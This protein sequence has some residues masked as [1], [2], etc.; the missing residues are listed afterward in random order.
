MVSSSILRAVRCGVVAGGVGLLPVTAHA[1][2]FEIPLGE[3]GI[4]AV[5]NTTITAGAQIRTQDRSSDLV[6]KSA[7][8]PDVCGRQA[9][10]MPLNQLCVGLFREQS[11]LAERLFNAPGQASTNN[12][13]GNLNY[14]RGD[15]TQAPA[16]VTSDLTLEFG[17]YGIFIKALYFHDF[18]NNDFTEFFPSA[19]NSANIDAAGFVATPD[20]TP[21]NGRPDSRP[22]GARN[23]NP[24]QPCG[25]V[26]FKGLPVE[27]PR[28]DRSTLRQIGENIQL[29]D[30]NFY[31]TLPLWG[32]EELSFKIGRQT[33][34]WGESTLLVLN[35]INQAQ[36]VNANNF[37]R[38]GFAVEEVFTPIASLFVGMSPFYNATLEAYYQFE[39]LPVEAPAP[40]SFFAF[41][42]LG[43]DNAV[44]YFNIGFGQGLD[45]PE[46][47][48]F[49]GDN[50]LSGITNT[51]GRGLRLRDNEPDSQG[52]FGVSLRY[53]AENLNN[54]TEIGL[55][56]MN[57]HSKLPYISF[58][59]V[60]EACSKNSRSTAD[61]FTRDCTDVPV[62]HT[63]ANDPAGATDSALPLDDARLQFEYP[64]NIQ[65]YG[66]SF[67]TT[68]G[69]FSL[70]GEVAYRPNMP[71]QVDLE[72]LAFAAFGP[73][74]TNCH[75]AP[76]CEGTSSG[77]GVMADG[78][79]GTYGSSDFVV[80]A[81]GT[82]GAFNDTFSLITGHVP[83]S[84]RAFPA[85]VTAYRGGVV[86]LNPGSDWS[87]P[88]DR[89]NPGY[90]Q[91]WE[92]FQVF[93]FNLGG[94]YV[95]GASDN[96]IGADQIIYLFETGATWV[97]DLPA[98]D[99][100]QLEAPG[101][102]YHASAGNDGSGSDG[103]RQACSTNA[104]CSFGPDGTRFNPHQQDLSAFPDKLSYGY[105]LITL[106]RYESV[107][108]GISIQPLIV[109]QHDVKGTAPG[110][111][112]NFVESR[113]IASALVETRYKSALSFTL[114]Y[115]W[116]TG[117]GPNHLLRDRDNAQA[118]VKYQF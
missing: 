21:P 58:Y 101:T 22:C 110:P 57:Y 61:F 55:Y 63:P 71:L 60:R 46:G 19:V 15:L 64:E 16:K 24:L 83:G 114:G 9:N 42:D 95:A 25:L 1:I 33:I 20:N 44:N 70:Q 69:D 54:G 65:M 91:G 43:T 23:P 104:A 107:L 36:P 89:N 27:Q 39:W 86:G 28:S 13:N 17:N 94:T 116:F 2:S 105:R 80:D 97:P 73:T 53:F 5:L 108:P 68:V 100:L 78:T 84:G 77:S 112:E 49:L 34:N 11:F 38:V 50:P 40:G 98:L 18:V 8:N 75:I 4:T 115:T 118:F 3:D 45:D 14:N 85:F 41:A 6:S 113:K 72:D 92:E 88:F 117:G 66:I 32:E 111:G 67:N 96:P 59:A 10:G 81:N 103:S 52:Q 29:L 99:Q 30:A 90:I 7:L 35:S 12:D 74:L 48:A 106:I 62:L 47:I 37:T 56:A 109:W 31:G 79:S 82:P 102:F 87:Q 51:S 26:Y 93:Q 76:G